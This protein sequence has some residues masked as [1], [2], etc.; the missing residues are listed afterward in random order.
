MP[1]IAYRESEEFKGLDGQS[2]PARELLEG[3]F[4]NARFDTRF[5]EEIQCFEPSKTP[6]TENENG[7]K[8]FV[9]SAALEPP[10]GQDKDFDA[11]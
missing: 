3:I 6:T 10:S 11:W 4:K 9:I 1:D 8:R 2:E 5:Y 7:G